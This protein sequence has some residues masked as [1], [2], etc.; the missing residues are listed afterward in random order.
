M[1]DAHPQP[2]RA[3]GP[4]SQIRGLTVAGPF[5]LVKPAALDLAARASAVYYLLTEAARCA[6]RA[7]EALETPRPNQAFV[8]RCLQDA[9]RAVGAAGAGRAAERRAVELFT[10]HN[11]G[12]HSVKPSAAHAAALVAAAAI[13]DA[14]AFDAVW[15]EVE[16]C[17]DPQRASAAMAAVLN[18]WVGDIDDYRHEVAAAAAV[19]INT[20]CMPAAFASLAAHGG[21]TLGAVLRVGC[22]RVP[23]FPYLPK[24]AQDALVRLVVHGQE[25]GIEPP[26][27]P[28]PQ[29][30]IS[31]IKQGFAALPKRPLRGEQ[32]AP[33]V[34]DEAARHFRRAG[35][36]VT[37]AGWGAVISVDKSHPASRGLELLAGAGGLY[38]PDPAPPDPEIAPFDTVRSPVAEG[39]RRLALSWLH[40]PAEVRDATLAYARGWFGMSDPSLAA[41]NDFSEYNPERYPDS[42]PASPVAILDTPALTTRLTSAGGFAAGTPG[43]AMGEH[44]SAPPDMRAAEPDGPVGACSY[45]FGGVAVRLSGLTLRLVG[46]LWDEA[47]GKPLSA[48]EVTDV[49]EDVYPGES[50]ADQKFDKLVKDLRKRLEDSAVP[51]RIEKRS[52]RVALIA[53]QTSA[54]PPVSPENL[55]ESDA[56][57]VPIL[58]QT[59]PGRPAASA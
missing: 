22:G 3:V 44:E 38:E 29:T 46:S 7:A 2:G 30:V 40:R 13:G 52:G 18:E 37:A 1:S 33:E 17:S 50:K 36:E 35:A 8:A 26:R 43:H 45:R 42:P 19:F 55:P 51:F 24:P 54:V 10:S 20:I 12:D 58:P 23:G 15:A 14:E 41:D 4:V 5:A 11:S 57:S 39:V 27:P 34:Y 28:H 32:R 6:S 16:Q 53:D 56:D 31:S 59:S 9:G 47:G 25:G 21:E 49:M 48:R